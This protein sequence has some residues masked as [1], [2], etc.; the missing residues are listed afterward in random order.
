MPSPVPG[1]G[2]VAQI[3]GCQKSR[4]SS[5]DLN[6]AFMSQYS[7]ESMPDANFESGSFSSFVDMT[8][9]IPHE[10]GNKL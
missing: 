10:E 8:S 1:G 4:L 5:T 7:P 9:K 3:S 2:G 6:E